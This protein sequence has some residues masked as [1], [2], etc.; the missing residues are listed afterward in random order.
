[1]GLDCAIR[2]GHGSPTAT[3]PWID[4][5]PPRKYPH[6]TLNL[7]Y[8]MNLD[9]AADPQAHLDDETRLAR[10][11][12]HL[13]K[14][15]QRGGTIVEHDRFRAVIEVTQKSSMVP[16]VVIAALGVAM[17]LWVGGVLFLL[18]AGLALLGWHRKLVEGAR[19]I[20]LLVRVDDLGQV[21]EMEM[22]T[23]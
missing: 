15:R 4:L 12:L 21:S 16:N 22:G 7:H 5:L 2:A 9:P 18:G 19:Q 8:I 14:V 11:V 10:L 23:A 17:F 6:P 20:R 1:M 3:N 13:A